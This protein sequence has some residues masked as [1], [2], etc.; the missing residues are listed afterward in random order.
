MY[1]GCLYS[2]VMCII[3]VCVFILDVCVCVH[4]LIDLNG[5]EVLVDTSEIHRGNRSGGKARNH[6]R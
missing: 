2:S 4:A 5:C 3:Y 1:M 6:S